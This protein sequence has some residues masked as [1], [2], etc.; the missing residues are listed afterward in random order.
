MSS[1]IYHEGI[2]NCKWL[3]KFINCWFFKGE[4]FRIEKLLYASFISI[5]KN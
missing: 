5:K 1:F 3:S 4:K 2:F